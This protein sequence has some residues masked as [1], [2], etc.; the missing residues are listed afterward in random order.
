MARCLL[1]P[2]KIRKIETLLKNSGKFEC[3]KVK[4]A[5]VRGGNTHFWA[6]VYLADGTLVYINYKSGEYEL[7]DAVS[8]QEKRQKIFDDAWKNGKTEVE[9][10]A[11][12][13]NVKYESLV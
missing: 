10:R 9:A 5:S 1:G 7:S 11:L 3:Y 13:D 2:K 4:N 8:L 12:A 6:S